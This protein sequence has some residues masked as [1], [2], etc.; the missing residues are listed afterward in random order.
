MTEHCYG[1]FKK[2]VDKV[3]AAKELEDRT[4]VL[5]GVRVNVVEVD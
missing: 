4:R 5:Q 3:L 2:F 1:M